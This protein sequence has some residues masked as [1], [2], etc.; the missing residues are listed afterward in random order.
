L[1]HELQQA[2]VKSRVLVLLCSP[3]AAVSTWVR[4]EIELFLSHGSGADV[5]AVLLDGEPAE[6]I[7][8]AIRSVD[9]RFHDVRRGWRLGFRR[10]GAT[11]E[12]LRLLAK[13]TN[14]EL[15]ELINWN[16]RRAIWNVCVAL[17]VILVMSAAVGTG[18]YE[19]VR[20]QRQ[21]KAAD[22]VARVALEVD[23]DTGEINQA[24]KLSELLKDSTVMSVR[25]LPGT[26]P[27]DELRY[28]WPL[29]T[30]QAIP[31][32]RAIE[33]TSNTQ[34][35]GSQTRQTVDTVSVSSI[36]TFTNFSGELGLLAAPAA[37]KSAVVEVYV[38]GHRPGPALR[39]EGDDEQRV[40]SQQRFFKAFRI[41]ETTGQNWTDYNI[42]PV[43]VAGRVEL[44]V[45]GRTIASGASLVMREWT[46][47]E[48]VS[49]RYVLRFPLLD[50]TTEP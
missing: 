42:Q 25:I 10:P 6:V 35:I 15:R 49:G 16:R 2:L 17:A 43:G 7:P 34:K 13:I 39:F 40:K 5:A 24:Q 1:G 4:T 38:L 18:A 8:E 19:Y 14:V 50:V 3:Q 20:S 48:D 27:R 12:L 21:I 37:W 33:L 11:Q 23:G 9:V 45:N 36:R 46:H 29:D 32:S 41:D 30:A 28:D 44:V 22:I 31:K 26:A 47:D